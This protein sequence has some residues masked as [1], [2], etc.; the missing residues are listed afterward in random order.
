MTKSAEDNKRCYDVLKDNLIE[1]RNVERCVG[2]IC[3]EV[4]LTTE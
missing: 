2:E 4:S 3:L 1:R